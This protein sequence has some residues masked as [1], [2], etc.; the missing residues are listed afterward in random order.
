MSP[1]Y[2]GELVQSYPFIFTPSPCEY[3]WAI[4]ARVIVKN[5]NGG[6]ATIANH[7]DKQSDDANDIG[8]EVCITAV[9]N[10]EDNPFQYWIEESTGRHIVENPYTFT[11]T[12]QDAYTPYFG[13]S[14]EGIDEVHVSKS[15]TGTSASYTLDG[16]RLRSDPQRGAFIKNG[17]KLVR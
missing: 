17:K 12:H 4:F 7:S 10:S 3:C 14:P 15:I 13:S 5:A 2:D 8:D 6:K 16:K 1:W 9:A 11:V